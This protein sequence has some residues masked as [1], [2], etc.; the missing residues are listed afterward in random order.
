MAA[1][2][3]VGVAFKRIGELAAAAC[4]QDAIG[5]RGGKFVCSERPSESAEA[6]PPN[7]GAATRP[8]RKSEHFAIGSFP[9]STK[10]PRTCPR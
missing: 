8:G 5:A 4:Q 10:R 3:E 9:N 6:K 7:A 2:G 1:Q